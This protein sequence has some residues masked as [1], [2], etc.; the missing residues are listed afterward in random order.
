MSLSLAAEFGAAVGRSGRLKQRYR[1]AP[2]CAKLPMVNLAPLLHATATAW[3]RNLERLFAGMQFVLGEQ[4]ETFE[5]E[6]AAALGAAQVVGVGTGT[7]AIELG[8]RAAG[9][10]GR[11]QEVIVPALTSPFTALAIC[12]AGARPVFADVDPDRLLIDPQDAASRITSR[13]AA[14]VPV[15][16]YGQVCD[17]RRLS[18]LARSAR[19]AVIQDA[20]QAHGATFDGLPLTRFSRFVAYSFYPTKNLGCLGDGGAIATRSAKLA[21]KLR[22]LRDGGRGRDQLSRC[23]AVNS[24]LDELQAC[25]LRAFLPKLQEWNAN[26]AQL[27]ELYDEALSLCPAVRP[28]LRGPESVNH[29]YVIRVPRRQSL[30]AYLAQQNIG[31]AVHYSVPLHL[32][33]AFAEFRRGGY[34]HAEQACREILSLPLWPYMRDSDVLTVAEHIRRFFAQERGRRRR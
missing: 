12:N 34:P 11:T 5:Q 8:L 14:I 7:G 21:A 23:P 2:S 25:F 27:A 30:R 19:L 13:T 3:Q 24:R 28:V 16:L 32:H 29:L 6:F 33:P 31:S 1:P 20:C 15:H 22:M 9:I 4:V 18:A 10:W 26:R 17:L